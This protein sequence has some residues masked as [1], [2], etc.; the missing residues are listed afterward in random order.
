MLLVYFKFTFVK[1]LL[2]ISARVTQKSC[3]ASQIINYSTTMFQ[4]KFNEAKYLTLGVGAVN[5]A[6]TLV[7]VSAK[8]SSYLLNY[9]T[10]E[11]EVLFRT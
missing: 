10:V 1:A 3:F 5:L 8:Y 4:A 7:A 6:F 2:C 11:C 9:D